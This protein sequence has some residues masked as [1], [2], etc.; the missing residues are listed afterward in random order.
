MA[1]AEYDPK[2]VEK[3]W[4]ED[5]PAHLT[6]LRDEFEQLDNPEK[7]DYENTL[8]KVAEK[9]EIGAGKLIHPV[10]L[11]VSG[12]G[13]GPGVYDLLVTIGKEEVINRINTA[14]DSI[15]ID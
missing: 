10:R 1:P 3:R 7:E 2:I 8:K 9:L 14:L 13:V 12:I 6:N 5:T 4:K 11:S 15:K